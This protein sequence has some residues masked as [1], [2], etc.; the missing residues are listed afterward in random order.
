MYIKIWNAHGFRGLDKNSTNLKFEQYRIRFFGV[1]EAHAIYGRKILRINQDRGWHTLIA[2]LLFKIPHQMLCFH[3]TSPTRYNE[4]SPVSK[5]IKA[6]YHFWGRN[7][8]TR[9]KILL[10]GRKDSGAKG[11]VGETT[12]GRSEKWAK[13]PGGETTRGERESGRNDSG[14]NG[15]VGETTRIHLHMSRDMTKPTKWLCAQRRLRSAW[16]STQPDQSL[17]C[18]L[19]G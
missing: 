10:R 9:N 3:L 4:K 16:A 19:N 5:K 15:K 13:R 8:N 11:K 14:A 18:A 1:T 7:N 17:R 6:L 2:G 12:Q